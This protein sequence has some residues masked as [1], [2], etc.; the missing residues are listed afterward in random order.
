MIFLVGYLV[1]M[2]AV[3]TAGFLNEPDFLA[4]VIAAVIP[5]LFVLTMIPVMVWVERKGSAYIQDRAGPERAFVPWLGIRLAG[6]VHPIADMVKLA[7]KEELLPRH[8]NRVLYVGAP[9]L[10]LFISLVVGAVIPYAHP[11]MLES[12]V[13]AVQGLNVNVGILWVLACAGIGVYAVVLAGWASNNK[14]SQLAGLRA[15]ASMI[16]YEITMGLAVVGALMVYQNVDLND[17]VAH[18]GGLALEFPAPVGRHHD[19]GGLPPVP[20]GGLRRDQ[21]DALRSERGGVRAGGRLPHRVRLLQVRALLHGRVRGHH[22]G[23]VPDRGHPLLRGL[24]ARDP[25][26]LRGLAAVGSCRSGPSWPRSVSSCSC[27]SGCAGRCRGSA[28]IS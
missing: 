10:S 26:A 5:W 9:V 27:S 23:P 11:V 28:T 25:A 3:F 12:G 7:F 2:V 21:P 1:A 24:A 8:V 18:Q 15:S 17:M 20:G 4:R 22:R 13:F 6:L 19:A 16:S 14:Y